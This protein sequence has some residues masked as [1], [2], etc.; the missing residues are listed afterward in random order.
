MLRD[1]WNE[2]RYRLRR[3][4]GGDAA[5]HEMAEE[6]QFHLDS[7]IERLVREGLSLSEARREAR[8]AFGGVEQIKEEARDAWGTRLIEN[9]RRDLG[10]SMRVARKQP[11]F[12][13]IVVLSLALGLG[14]TLTA[15]NITWNVLFA[16]VAL[17]HPEQLVQPWRWDR[18]GRDNVFT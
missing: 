15:F 12:S 17:P 13:L 5:E 9:V 6:I 11:G 7:E 10:Q 8:R 18:G 16:E 2:I 3:L 1:L 14:A 4:T